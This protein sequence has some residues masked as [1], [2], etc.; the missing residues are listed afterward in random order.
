MAI[1]WGVIGVVTSTLVFL[2]TLYRNFK[3]DDMDLID[4]VY[5]LE[6][7]T[8]QLESTLK[9]EMDSKGEIQERLKTIETSLQELNLAVAR[10][11]VQLEHLNKK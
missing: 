10:L 2:Y 7:R 3:T 8:K 9:A 6:S 4:R 5:K 1:E 11:I